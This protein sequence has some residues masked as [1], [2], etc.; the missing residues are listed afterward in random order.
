MNER[1][2]RGGRRGDAPSW[3]LV[4]WLDADNMAEDLIDKKWRDREER[5]RYHDHIIEVLERWTQTHTVADLVEK[6]QLMHF[7]WAEIT[8]IPRLE[9][10]LN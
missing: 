2:T 7:P 3:G 1:A 5:L 4:E 6:G 9:L 10:V 8:S